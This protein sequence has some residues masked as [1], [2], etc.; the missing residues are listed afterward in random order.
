MRRT[1]ALWTPTS[2]DISYRAISVVRELRRRLRADPARSSFEPCLP[3]LAKE[4]PAGPGW[5]HEIKHDGFRIVAHRDTRGM[6]LIRSGFEFRI[7]NILAFAI[8]G[9]LFALTPLATFAQSPPGRL[10]P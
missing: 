10:S 3:R 5:I 4:P 9:A 1:S 8:V 2:P 7:G 6:R